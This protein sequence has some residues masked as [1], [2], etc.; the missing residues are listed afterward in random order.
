MQHGRRGLVVEEL[1]LLVLERLVPAPAPAGVRVRRVAAD[2]PE[3]DLARIMA[4]APLAFGEGGTAVGA[5]GPAERDAR[6]AADTADR[7]RLRER[8]AS[9]ATVLIVA[10]DAD[11]PDGPLASGVH[12]PI[13]GV[14]EIVAVAT[15]PAARRRGLASAVTAALAED[16]LASRVETVYL[17]ASAEAVARIYERLGFRRA[18]TAGV[19]ERRAR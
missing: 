19:A 9:G 12:Q 17:S 6:A 14:T 7:S 16:A 5:A 1:P 15:L 3:A 8:I 4:I 2:E 10:E 13:D 18:A 11:G